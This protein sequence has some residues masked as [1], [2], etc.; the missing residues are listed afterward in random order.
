M[1]IQ[2]RIIRDTRFLLRD[3]PSACFPYDAENCAPARKESQVLLQKETAFELGGRE[4]KS[5][6]YTCISSTPGIVGQSATLVYGPDLGQIKG[7]LSYARITFAETG[8]IGEDD[9]AYHICKDIDLIKYSV[10]PEGFMVRA[11]SMEVREQV[12]VGKKAVKDGLTFAQTGNLFIRNYLE[13]P[14]V[15]AVQVLFITGDTVDFKALDQLAKKNKMIT[16]A[17]NKIMEKADKEC[18]TCG[19]KEICDEVEGLRKM[20]FQNRER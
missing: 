7:P 6:A 9:R 8:D 14:G 16:K 1:E 12:R 5:A 11:S 19:L 20:H 3:I 18:S 13:Y 2:D 15:K 10:Y 17:L 4:K